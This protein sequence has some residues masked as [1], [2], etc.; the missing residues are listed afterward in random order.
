LP[1]GTDLHAPHL[2]F[3]IPTG[4][5]AIGYGAGTTFIWPANSAFYPVFPNAVAMTPELTATATFLD[6]AAGGV[7]VSA[8][9]E[10]QFTLLGPLGVI[11]PPD[12]LAGQDE[13]ERRRGN[14]LLY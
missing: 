5:G 1:G 10:Y 4:I 6:A 7:T 13:H 3:A 8:Y 11:V 12:H 2:P 9:L 14:K